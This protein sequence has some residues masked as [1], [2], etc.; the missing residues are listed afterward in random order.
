MTN[1]IEVPSI[2]PEQEQ[3]F[4]FAEKFAENQE[5][6]QSM[7]T[8]LREL[9][10]I[11]LEKLSD[12]DWKNTSKENKRKFRLFGKKEK[13]SE[14]EL[15]ASS[16]VGLLI[17]RA[18]VRTWELRQE[19]SGIREEQ[20]ILQEAVFALISVEEPEP[21]PEAGFTLD[22]LDLSSPPL[23][24]DE[25]DEARVLED[26]EQA[27]EDLDDF[28]EV[29][30]LFKLVKEYADNPD[31]G[32][33][34]EIKKRFD[35]VHEETKN[36][37]DDS[38]KRLEELEEEL[39]GDVVDSEKLEQSIVDAKERI[40]ILEK[41][42]TAL[43]EDKEQAEKVYED[44]RKFLQTEHANV[45]IQN[46]N[47]LLMRQF[48]LSLRVANCLVDRLIDH[49]IIWPQS[50]DGSFSVNKEKIIR[51]KESE[52]KIAKVVEENYVAVV[53]HFVEEFG[54]DLVDESRLMN[55]LKQTYFL[56]EDEIEVMFEKLEQEGVVSKA[57]RKGYRKVSE[58]VV[59]E[60]RE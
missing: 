41:K 1:P 59:L 7:V 9:E 35:N 43:P 44:A 36:I 3:D 2:T 26:V 30:R 54:G 47:T 39:T 13:M 48:G 24:D 37:I 38:E 53:T 19:I 58:E 55:M 25:A 16:E 40:D 34:Q 12:F 29:E 51:E 50:I 57:N 27:I 49:S 11:D 15:P 42:I 20:A 6:L 4:D 21:I 60:E 46:I 52:E 28:E 17:N 14:S 32:K 33:K 5:R 56:Q 8:E 22:D 31:E 10:A 23:P 45:R 18:V